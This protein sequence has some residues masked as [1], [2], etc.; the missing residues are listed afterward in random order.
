[1]SAPLTSKKMSDGQ[2][3]SGTKPTNP[4][5][6]S[7]A[8][9]PRGHSHH[10]DGSRADHRGGHLRPGRG[11]PPS[12]ARA[13]TQQDDKGPTL[14]R[15]PARPSDAARR[16]PPGHEN[17]PQRRKREAPGHWEGAFTPIGA[18][19]PATLLRRPLRVPRLRTP[20]PSTVHP[21]TTQRRWRTST[22]PPSHLPDPRPQ[23]DHRHLRRVTRTARRPVQDAN[24]L[25]LD[26]AGR[27]R[28]FQQKNSKIIPVSSESSS[29]PL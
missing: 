2:E 4:P 7:T 12:A 22:V 29:S 6:T 19:A 20:T 15:A 1:M 10:S 13:D 27:F 9:D 26:S 23:V 18:S 28:R 11:P 8:P 14:P 17:L 21:R 16:T 25:E 3:P 5:S 24:V